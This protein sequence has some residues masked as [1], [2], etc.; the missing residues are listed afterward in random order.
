MSL[1]HLQAVDPAIQ[2]DHE[3]PPAQGTEPPLPLLTRP[4]AQ[5][6]HAVA[7]AGAA[8]VVAHEPIILAS[9]VDSLGGEAHASPC[10]GLQMA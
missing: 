9:F 4:P 5:E 8:L 2:I 6:P 7:P 10:R 1:R 3:Q